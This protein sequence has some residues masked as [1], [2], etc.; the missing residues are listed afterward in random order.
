[1]HTISNTVS[2]CQNIPLL[3]VQC[4]ANMVDAWNKIHKMAELSMP[5]SWPLAMNDLDFSCVCYG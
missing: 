4:N 5:T 1:M 3:Q 2:D